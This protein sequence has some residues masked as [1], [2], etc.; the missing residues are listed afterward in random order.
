MKIEIL[1][2]QLEEDLDHLASV[3]FLPTDMFV[4]KILKEYVQSKGSVDVSNFNQS[5]SHI[6]K[7]AD[8]IITEFNIKLFNFEQRYDVETSI[9]E[10]NIIML[11][12][13]DKYKLRIIV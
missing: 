7:E 11:G 8:K 13:P 10:N 4:A 3:E 2:K 12:K 5:L 9:S 6:K 1:N